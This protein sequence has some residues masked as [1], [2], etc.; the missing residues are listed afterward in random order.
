MTSTIQAAAAA[1]EAAVVAHPSTV[2]RR[3]L[4]NQSFFLVDAPDGMIPRGNDAGLGLYHRDT[5]FLSCFELTLNGTEPVP[6]LSSTETGYL[7]TLVYTNRAFPTGQ[8]RVPEESVQLR[9]ETVVNQGLC[10]R[11]TLITYHTEPVQAEVKI[12]LGADF[13]DIFDVRQLVTEA[14]GTVLP[15]T[16][17]PDG[18]TLVFGYLDATGETLRTRIGFGDPLP[19]VRVFEP[20]EGGASLVALHYT[21]TLTPMQPV[22]IQLHCQV[23]SPGAGLGIGEG[24]GPLG[25][26]LQHAAQAAAAWE[27]QTTQFETDNAD[28]NEILARCQKDI[29]MLLNRD[30][31]HWFVSAGIP[32]YTCLFGRDSLITARD[33]LMLN[34]LLARDTLHLLARYQGKSTDPKRDEA[35]GKILHELRLGELA[36]MGA[37]PHTPYYGTVDATPLWLILLHDY[38]V[39]THDLT[40]LQ[41]LWPHALSAMAWIDTE[42]AQDPRGYLTYCSQAGKGLLHQGWKDSRNSAMYQDGRL[43][44]PPIALAEVQGYV[45][46]AKQNLAALAEWMGDKTLRVRLKKEAHALKKRFN[47]D[48]WLPELGF[49]ALGLDADGAPLDVVASNIGH[50]L[51]TGLLSAGRAKTVGQRLM[52]PDMFSGWGIRTLSAQM[53]AYNPISYHNGTIWPHDNAMIARGFARQGHPEWVD[54][55]FTGLFEAARQMDYKRLPELF[56]GFERGEAGTGD[57]PVRYPVACSPQA[58]AASSVFSLTQS[59]LNL[60]PDLENHRLLIHRPKLPHWINRLRLKNFRVGQ[61]VL[62]LEFRRTQH[63]VLVD[64]HHRQGRLD[65]LLEI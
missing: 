37:I 25:P 49:Y 62:D 47:Q 54:T 51:E 36:R 34:P 53:A 4:K 28:F 65:L 48:F 7:S 16:L 56:C 61:A 63:T 55:V 12:T 20:S 58:W 15:P 6:L 26:A 10:E 21:L 31:E 57:P 39:W 27:A 2:V 43:A 45:Y 8:G 38:F 60:T 35:P 29:R 17:E 11:L 14:R 46:L 50:C 40:T 33:C 24:Y 30:G 3:T 19:T 22:S 41:Q 42:M 1:A 52:M 44:E 18:R 13:R 32:W 9:R 5:R 64:V 23:E 59:L